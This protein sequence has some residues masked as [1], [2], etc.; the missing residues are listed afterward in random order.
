MT[1]L[2][3]GLGSLIGWNAVLISLDLLDILYPEKNLSFFIPI[4]F[5]LA[6]NLLG[7]FIF[8]LSKV[9]RMSTRIVSGLLL[10]LDSP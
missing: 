4:P 7:L 9:T 5:F 3:L 2:M 6:T 10:Y 1:F 8:S